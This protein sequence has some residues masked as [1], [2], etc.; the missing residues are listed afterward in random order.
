MKQV[1]KGNIYLV[2][3]NKKGKAKKTRLYLS[4]KN[5]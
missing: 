2:D 1:C 5:I 4:K 3:K